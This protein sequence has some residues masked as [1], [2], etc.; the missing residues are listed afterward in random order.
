[1]KKDVFKMEEKQKELNLNE[2][3]LEEIAG[4]LNKQD[5]KDATGKVIKFGKE[6]VKEILLATTA[7]ASVSALAVGISTKCDTHK[8]KKDISPEC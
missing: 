1:M 2:A 8:L 6:N 3:Q 4:G 7:I 5:I